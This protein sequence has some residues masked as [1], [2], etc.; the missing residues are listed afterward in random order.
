MNERWPVVVGIDFSDSSRRALEL[1]AAVC[2][3]ASVPLELVHVWNTA[4]LGSHTVLPQ[5]W[6]DEQRERLA[7]KLEEWAGQASAAASGAIP[8]VLCR[9]VEGGPSR[10]LADASAGAGLLVVGRRG[11]ANLAHVLLG[12]VSERIMHLVRCPV[13]VVPNREKTR[14][15]SPPERLLVGIDFS[16]GAR[17][18]YRAALAL[19]ERVRPARGL[20][21]LHAR[22]SEHERVLEGWSELA[23]PKRYPHDRDG[24]EAWAEIPEEGSLAIKVR[25]V[26]GRPEQSLQIVARDEAC[27][28]LVIGVR[29]RTAIEALLVGSTTDRVLKAT[30]R[31][32]VVVPAA[33]GSPS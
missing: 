7:A 20:L 3:R 11:S 2:A 1:A 4:A 23:H 26:E 30:D 14:S 17:D 28:W 19:A 15:V 33:T 8:E 18:A 22:P 5:S 31:P 21:L 24:L 13:V 6:A 32:V 16:N 9:V 10:G 25:V 29:G 12:S 27:D